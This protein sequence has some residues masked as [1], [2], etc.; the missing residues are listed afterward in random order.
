MK[1]PILS[2]LIIFLSAIL[3]TLA[4]AK[5]KKIDRD[6]INRDLKAGRKYRETVLNPALERFKDRLLQDFKLFDK[7]MFQ[8]VEI[9]K[10]NWITLW[11]MA[12]DVSHF[13]PLFVGWSELKEVTPDLYTWL[14]ANPRHVFRDMSSQ[15]PLN[16]TKKVDDFFNWLKSHLANEYEKYVGPALRSDPNFEELKKAMN[17]KYPV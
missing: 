1:K 6:K 9:T 15:L 16:R 2:S 8:D 14:K 3:V 11:V 12:E 5:D 4:S 17:S 10:P 13:D 7:P